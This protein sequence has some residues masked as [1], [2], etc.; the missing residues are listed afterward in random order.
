MSLKIKMTLELQQLAFGFWLFSF[1]TS[2]IS[3]NILQ[4]HVSWF[5]A[6]GMALCHFLHREAAG[7]NDTNTTIKKGYLICRLSTHKKTEFMEQMAL[8]FKMA[9]V[10]HSENQGALLSPVQLAMQVTP[11]QSSPATLLGRVTAYFLL[12]SKGFFITPLLFSLF[13]LQLWSFPSQCNFS[14]HC[15]MVPTDDWNASHLLPLKPSIW[16]VRYRKYSFLLQLSHLNLSIFQVLSKSENLQCITMHIK[17]MH[18]SI[19]GW[20]KGRRR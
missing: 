16:V 9:T 10:K 12:G 7:W 3:G 1:L 4:Y 13:S 19:C 6:Q 15:K 18:K 14:K 2:V 17:Y 20:G 8:E 5:L 11:R